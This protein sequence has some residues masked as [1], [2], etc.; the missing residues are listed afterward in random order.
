[1][2]VIA[3]I[4]QIACSRKR[5]SVPVSFVGICLLALGGC[6]SSPM[7][8]E[9]K[10][11]ADY[12]AETTAES[13]EGNVQ[14]P[15]FVVKHAHHTGVILPADSAARVHPQIPMDFAQQSDYQVKYWEFGWGDERYY[16]ARYTDAV[17]AVRAI[18]AP[19]SSLVHVVGLNRHPKDYFKKIEYRSL[20]VSP[21]EY[22]NMLAYIRRSLQTSPEGRLTQTI[23]SREKDRLFF[24]GRGEYALFNNC[25]HW[26][27]EVLNIGG[28]E[29]RPKT[30]TGGQIM[31]QVGGAEF[32]KP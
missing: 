31:A 29:I 5:K 11:A 17:L 6:A 3:T 8:D 19:T 22:E 20:S 21:A 2:S 28:V 9:V 26:T 7:Y 16:T 18:I 12:Q 4:Y 32:T 25:N 27:A 30:M 24:K 23:E 13:D 14:I 15:I 10:G 1:M